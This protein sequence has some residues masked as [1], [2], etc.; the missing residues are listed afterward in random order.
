M[1]CLNGVMNGDSCHE[2]LNWSY[3]NR[4]VF[5]FW[6][7][8]I[9]NRNQKGFFLSPVYKH[10]KGEF[11]CFVGVFLLFFFSKKHLFKDEE[12]HCIAN[13]GKTAKNEWANNDSDFA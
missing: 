6:K 10:L 2:L 9:L 3:V 11:V 7:L 1:T 5:W 4:Y 13:K 8:L 12:F